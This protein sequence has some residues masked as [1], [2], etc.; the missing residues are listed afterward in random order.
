[1][2]SIDSSY[3]TP[4]GMTGAGGGNM[5]RI[6]G[7]ATGL[8]VDA[9]VKKMMAAEQVKLDKAKQAQ[10][11]IQWKQDAYKD[12]IK[13]IK[14]LQ[15]SFFDSASPDKNI[16]SPMNFSPFTVSGIG[17][18]ALDTSVATF[19]PGVGAQTGTYSVTVKQLAAGAGVNNSLLAGKTL[20]TK[21]TDIDSSLTGNIQLVLNSGGSS[22]ITVSLN[23][24]GSATLGDLINAINN[25]SSG[26][27]NAKFSELTGEFKLSN[28][29]TGSSSK[30]T[31]KAGTTANL[32]N[33]VGTGNS[34]FNIETS[35]ATTS[36]ISLI[37]GAELDNTLTGKIAL[38]QLS[39]INASLTD[40]STLILN[41]GTGDI[42]VNIAANSNIQG[43]VDAINTQASGSVTAKFDS[44]TNVISL[45]AN[46]DTASLKIAKGSTSGLFSVFG[47]TSG[48][49][50][51]QVG[52][53]AD[54]TITAGGS[55]VHF[56][57]AGGDQPGKSSNNFTIDGITYTLSSVS[58]NNGTTPT[59]ANVGNDAGKVYDKIKNLIDKYN[60]I[61]D[62]IQTKLTEKPDSNY[63]PLTDAQKSSMSESQIT[64][65]ENKAKAG[66][67]RNDNNLQTLLNDL[68]TAFST[69]VNNTGISIGRYGSN[70][71]GIDT[72]DYSNITNPNHIYIVD[73]SK[74]KDAIST[75][76]DQ[77]LKIFTNISS[78]TDADKSKIYD[79]TKIQYQEDG[80]FTRIN[81]ILQ[82][83][84]GFTNTTFNSAVL[85]SYANTQY[86]YSR[87]GSASKNTLPDQLYEQQLMIKKITDEMSTKQEKYYMQF[88][89]LETAMNRLNAQ[90]AMLSSMISG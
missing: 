70:S 32:S 12:I 21:L 74:F 10:Q 72:A 67:L 40:A 38:T 61:V 71:F 5:L 49:G 34:A 43:L 45:K 58:P 29:I 52:N 64:A 54:V 48:D 84:V 11:T 63:K 17:G 4:T 83:N 47:L 78:N 60:T 89:Q 68:K 44:A 42:N 62:G 33:I 35:A 2:S 53:N 23:N 8:D 65:W 57:D 1:M 26:S 30:L 7:M 79:N 51:T 19:T 41:T 87:T 50:T 73:E 46:S 59:V 85:T 75:K 31:I 14:D 36:D 69:A 9:M 90:Q 88:S 28:T 25:Q 82:K 86:D 39:D 77:I 3:T 22:D 24:T 55:T 6:T 80:I 13:D 15:S 16:L 20:N 56:A 81:K 37:A 18:V 66:V 76:G 27:V